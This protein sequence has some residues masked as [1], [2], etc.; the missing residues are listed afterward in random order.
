MVRTSTGSMFRLSVGRQASFDLES[1]STMDAK[2]DS[3]EEAEGRARSIT[4]TRRETKTMRME[5]EMEME[6]EI[7]PAN[8]PPRPDAGER[9]SYVEMPSVSSL[10]PP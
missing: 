5:M 10:L 9:A 2:T 1:N 6:I 3:R 4:N 8:S 7:E